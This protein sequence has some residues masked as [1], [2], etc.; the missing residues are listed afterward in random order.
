MQEERGKGRR[1]RRNRDR[2]TKSNQR[3]ERRDRIGGEKRRGG[4]KIFLKLLRNVGRA[5]DIYLESYFRNSVQDLQY[6]NPSKKSFSRRNRKVLR[7]SMYLLGIS[8]HLL[9]HLVRLYDE[10]C[11]RKRRKR[12]SLH[13]F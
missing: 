9:A 1:I 4:R 2:F 6:E 3:E 5:D 7:R 8:L 12:R 13:A 11:D 10:T